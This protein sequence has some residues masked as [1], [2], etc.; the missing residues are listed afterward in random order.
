[1]TGSNRRFGAEFSLVLPRSSVLKSRAK[2]TAMDNR[3]IKNEGQIFTPRRIV[4]N[5]LDFMGYRGSGILKKH[6]MENSCG[7]GA[8]LVAVVERYAAAF[9]KRKN[10]DPA[11]LAAELETYVHGIEKDAENVKICVE[12]LNAVAKRL[13]VSV[14]WDVACADTLNV[15]G[16]YGGR[17]DFVVGNPPYVRVHNLNDSYE[18][19]KK[20]AF[21]SAGMTDLYLVFFEIGLS[22]LSENGKMCLITPSSFLKS[23]AGGAFRKSIRANRF[24]TAVVDLEH[25]QPFDNATT[26][27]AI[28]LFD[29]SRKSGGVEYYR[30]DAATDENVFVD[31]I[32][33]DSLFIDGKMFLDTRKRLSLIKKIDDHY[34]RVSKKSVKVKNG[35]ATLADKIFIGDFA[36]GDM[37]IPV[38]KASTGKWSRCVFPYT[39][40]GAPLSENEIRTKHKAAYDYLLSNKS[41]LMKR[42]IE[43]SGGWYLFGRSQALKDVQKDKVAVNQLIRD[44]SSLK[45]NLAP[46]GSG[47][48]GGLYV[49][50]DADARKI[51]SVLNTDE[52]VDYVKSLKNYKSGGYYTYSSRDLEKYL[53]Y[54]L[55]ERTDYAFE[56]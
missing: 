18:S 44:K 38:L 9:L 21:S 24:L 12:N 46:R 40:D 52:F 6:V 4:D 10:A 39:A 47:V 7:R 2:G 28:S 14:N 41:D 30:Y 16:D 19:V 1:M 35:F 49:V 3:Q 42:S 31:E 53:T 51:A 15:C 48:Y 55:D 43:K 36:A 34:K 50:S 23:E 26:Y 54:K 56:F 20:R 45:I 32:D 5:M 27:T 33:Y 11:G 13:N 29:V 17:M 37:R 25:A 8:F 22:M